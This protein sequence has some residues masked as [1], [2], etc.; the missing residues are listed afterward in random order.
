[1]LGTIGGLIVVGGLGY[2]IVADAGAKLRWRRMALETKI[3]LAT[4]VALL[5]GGAA[6]VALAEW[7]N[8]ATLG[9]LPPE[10]RILNAAFLSVTSRTAGF[11]SLDTGALLP[12][13]LFLVMGL[14][15]VG[16]ASGSTAGGIKVNSL[17]VILVA[18]TSVARV[19]RRRRRS[20]DAC[21][22]ASSTGPWRWP[23]SAP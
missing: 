17:G 15:F 16:G 8:P 1:M 14:M 2:A 20:D 11:N 13:T 22:T 3:V 6:F 7:T 9:A 18:V 23:R 19:R 10:S 4:S 21:P 12:Q 5:V